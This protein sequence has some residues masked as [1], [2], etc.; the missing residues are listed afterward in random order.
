MDKLHLR[1]YIIGRLQYIHIL[2]YLA[3]KLAYDQSPKNSCSSK[4]RLQCYKKLIQQ[5]LSPLFSQTIQLLYIK[6]M[7]V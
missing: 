3:M 6:G 1:R 4:Q 7:V 2:E 5:L